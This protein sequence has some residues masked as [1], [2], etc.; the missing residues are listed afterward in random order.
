MKLVNVT[1]YD[2]AALRKLVQAVYDEHRQTEG[3]HNRWDK[4]V[5][6]VCTGRYSGCASLGVL[7]GDGF[8]VHGARM[9]LRLPATQKQR[10][11]VVQLQ[12]AEHCATCEMVFDPTRH[13][14]SRIAGI[15]KEWWHVCVP[16]MKLVPGE[17]AKTGTV[18]RLIEHELRHSYGERHKRGHHCMSGLWNDE[19]AAY[20]EECNRVWADFFEG[21]VVPLK[22]RKPKP[23]RDLVTERLTR[24]LEREKAWTSKLKRAQTALRKL[25]A[26]RRR[27]ET[28]MAARGPK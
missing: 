15:V 20:V 10:L 3:P 22:A 27:Y 28:K 26:A 2:T 24:V 25:R 18:A 17:Q 5:V 23:E 21:G 8:I 9:R 19:K 16:K 13:G 14:C 11:N 12:A 6:T 1:K 4:M 7:R